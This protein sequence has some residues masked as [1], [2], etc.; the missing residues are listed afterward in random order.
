[1]WHGSIKLIVLDFGGLQ[2][3]SIKFTTLLVGAVWV[4]VM[5][6]FDEVPV[7]GCVWVLST[8]G[9]AEDC[10]QALSLTLLNVVRAILFVSLLKFVIEVVDAIIKRSEFRGQ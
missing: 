3:I 1:M 10:G 8:G 7:R 6:I 2:A 9:S 5:V 4:V